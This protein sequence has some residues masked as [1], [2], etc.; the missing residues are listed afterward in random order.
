MATP[1]YVPVF[2]E[3][4]VLFCGVTTG[5]ALFLLFLRLPD[6]RKPIFH[7]SIT[8]DRFALAIEVSS[9]DEVEPVKK[10]LR[11]IQAQEIHSVEGAL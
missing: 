1:A 2:F 4:T 11:E 10:F 5:I 3:L 6:L 7:P 9:E 8:D